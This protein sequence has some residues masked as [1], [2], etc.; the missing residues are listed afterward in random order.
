MTGLRAA[1]GDY[2][3]LRRT[4]GFKLERTGG[5]LDS[6]IDFVELQGAATITIDLALQ[7]ATQPRN[8]TPWWWRQRLSVV[9]GFARYL[10]A[11]DP[12]TEIPPAG[13]IDS[14][15]P[16]SHALLVLRGR[17][18]RRH[19]SYRGPQPPSPR[20]DLSHAD[21]PAGGDGDASR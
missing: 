19:G 17:C 12:A 4:L 1:A 18:S 10:Q 3:A 15:P 6:F 14:P 7:W 21:R 11:I 20:R 16:P 8:A 13:L 2:L 5:L 9:R